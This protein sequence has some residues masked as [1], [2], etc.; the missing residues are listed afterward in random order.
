M[1]VRL[2][3]RIEAKGI[4]ATTDY[5]VWANDSPGLAGYLFLTPPDAKRK[6]AIEAYLGRLQDLVDPDVEVLG[7]LGLFPLLTVLHGPQTVN[8]EQDVERMTRYPTFNGLGSYTIPHGD[9]ELGGDKTKL[10]K[11]LTDLVRKGY[12]APNYKVIGSPEWVGA[13]VADVLGAKGNDTVDEVAGK[14]FG[15]IVLYHGTSKKRWD[16]IKTKGM[17]PGSPTGIDPEIYGDRVEGYTNRNLYF[18]TSVPIAEKY[19]TRAA[20]VDKSLGVV[21]AVE[22]N[23]LT[24]LVMDEDMTQNFRDPVTNAIYRFDGAKIVTVNH[25]I[26]GDMED[27][28]DWRS[29]PDMEEIESRFQTQLL[30][31]LRRDKTVAYRGFVRPNKI[32]LLETF[33]PTR[34]KKYPTEEEYGAAMTKTRNTLKHYPDPSRVANMF[35]HG[36][37]ARIASR[38]LQAKDWSDIEM[39]VG[40]YG[41]KLKEFV[42]LIEGIRPLETGDRASHYYDPIGDVWILLDRYG[43]DISRWA[44]ETRRI[45]PGKAK[46][47]EL[48]ARL[49]QA[50][51]RRP[52]NLIKWYD[53]NREKL[54]FLSEV[55]TWPERTGEDTLTLGSFEVH[56]TVGANEKV[57][58]VVVDV[59]EQA[60]RA[61]AAM[62]DF[63][64]VLYGP[65]FITGQVLKSGT[66]AWYYVQTDEV[67]VRANL[68]KGRGELHNL[69]HELGHRYWYRFLGATKQQAIARWFARIDRLEGTRTEMPKVGE[70]MPFE[71][72]GH[73]TPPIIQ[74]IEGTHFYIDEHGYLKFE[75]IWKAI[76]EED[77]RRKYPTPYSSTNEVEFFA[78]VFAMYVL[79]TLPQAFVADFEAA[80]A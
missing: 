29:Q 60:E 24:R 15:K 64:K 77:R 1:T 5:K 35:L 17:K 14:T 75:A 32:K 73:A 50:S 41:R 18:A 22:I 52:P 31:S 63:G 42:E 78:E 43:T 69:V 70:P 23:D 80:V 10:R 6:D 38:H 7:E 40:F 44:I 53:T 2:A 47:L 62:F 48:T 68:K 56:N 37:A 20:M 9:T 54:E 26:I 16:V 13:T 59:F 30:K 67:Y 19:A 12:L 72:K 39:K 51:K 71:M 34:M 46:L 65:V 76:R 74:R 55:A 49:F 11:I 8:L 25:P 57:M 66:L 61:I 79:G 36:T 3:Y 58:A 28:Q 21:L 4:G 45:P 33:K 27:W